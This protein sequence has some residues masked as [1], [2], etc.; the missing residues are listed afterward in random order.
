MTLKHLIDHETDVQITNKRHRLERTL[1]DKH[2]N[3]LIDLKDDNAR[4]ILA[5]IELLPHFALTLKD[6]EKL[7]D[8]LHTLRV[9]DNTNVSNQRTIDKDLR[10]INDD[11]RRVKHV[12][13]ILDYQNIDTLR[14][15]RLTKQAEQ[16]LS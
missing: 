10:T 3:I 5:K 8:A 11:H 6:V 12:E 16:H 9:F 13:R 15:R 1:H 4:K 2:K 7:I 14:H